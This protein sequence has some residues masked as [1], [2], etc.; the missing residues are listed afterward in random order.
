MYNFHK[1]DSFFYL[2]LTLPK[3][4]YFAVFFSKR[5]LLFQTKNN[6]HWQP[7]LK[8]LMHLR[9]WSDGAD[10]RTEAQKFFNAR[11]IDTT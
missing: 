9:F 3:C 5:L 2:I 10:F 1:F 4:T 7:I 8:N 6:L 11:T